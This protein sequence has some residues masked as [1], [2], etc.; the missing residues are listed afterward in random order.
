MGQVTIVFGS[1]TPQKS[2][3]GIF[4]CVCMKGEWE[5]SASLN[6][7]YI[8][9]LLVVY[10]YMY[11]CRYVHFV[12]NYCDCLHLL[13]WVNHI[14][15][16]HVGIN[17]LTPLWYRSFALTAIF[18]AISL[19]LL[20]RLDAPSVP[21]LSLNWTDKKC[22]QRWPPE[23]TVYA[24]S[25]WWG[26]DLKQINRKECS[27]VMS[28]FLPNSPGEQS[29]VWGLYIRYPAYIY[30]TD[31]HVPLFLQGSAIQGS[32]TERKEI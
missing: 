27:P 10:L 29:H 14:F 25:F 9:Y 24:K 13:G 31:W 30:V 32:E 20:D 2:N 22:H 23:Q 16:V 8:T 18:G 3:T 19:F 21:A 6:I 28:Q 11:M 15:I 4:L 1:L 26:H 7:L 5:T 12:S 17:A